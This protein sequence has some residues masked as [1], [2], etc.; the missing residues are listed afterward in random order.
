MSGEM[1]LGRGRGLDG[2]ASGAVELAAGCFGSGK[3]V[4]GCLIVDELIARVELTRGGMC[5][6][7]GRGSG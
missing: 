2:V 1:K 5:G 3:F 6:A 4:S 7:G